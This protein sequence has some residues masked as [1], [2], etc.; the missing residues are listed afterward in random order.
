[1]IWLGFGLNLV[2]ATPST[3]IW[4]PSTDVQS[5]KTVHLGIDNY[6]SVKDNKDNA[7]NHNKMDQRS[8]KMEHKSRRILKL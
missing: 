8:Y 3:Q 2:Y 6:Y 7:Y 4:N 1:M 5:F